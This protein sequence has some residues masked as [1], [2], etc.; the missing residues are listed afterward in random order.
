MCGIYDLSNHY[1][2]YPGKGNK[3]THCITTN[4]IDNVPSMQEKSKIRPAMGWGS[5]GGFSSESYE[6]GNSK[7]W[8]NKSFRLTEWEVKVNIP[9]HGC[10][11]NCKLTGGRDKDWKKQKHS[12]WK[13]CGVRTVVKKK[14]RKK[15]VDLGLIGID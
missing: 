2:F 13:K 5:E 1:S 11:M 12:W 4:L 8:P 14:K 15:E 10:P 9:G 3:K 6:P 7:I